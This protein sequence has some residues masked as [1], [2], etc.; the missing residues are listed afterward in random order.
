MTRGPFTK[1][2]VAGDQF[3]DRGPEL[4]ACRYLVRAVVDPAAA[5]VVVRDEVLMVRSRG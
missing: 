5:D 4:P 3:C 1:K 2:V